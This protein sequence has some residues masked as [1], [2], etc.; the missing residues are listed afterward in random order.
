MVLIFAGTQEHLSAGWTDLCGCA[1]NDAEA[2]D[3]ARD[4]LARTPSGVGWAQ[5]VT[6]YNGRMG[7]RDLRSEWRPGNVYHMIELGGPSKASIDHGELHAGGRS[8]TPR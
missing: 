6:L 5:I 2:I 1:T 3:I 8:H 7:C 4:Y